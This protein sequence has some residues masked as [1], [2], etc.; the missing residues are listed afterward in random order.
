[1]IRNHPDLKHLVKVFVLDIET[2]GFCKDKGRIIEIAIRD[3]L[4]GENSCFQT[5]VN[6]GQDIPNSH[7]HGITTEMVNQPH[8][9]RLAILRLV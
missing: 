9:P 3:L 4:G 7:V 1:M 8:I 5:L 2:T 6:P